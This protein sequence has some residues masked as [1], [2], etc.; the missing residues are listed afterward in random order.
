[1]AQARGFNYLAKVIEGVP[2]KDGMELT[3]KDQIAA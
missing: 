1:M 3:E 2:F